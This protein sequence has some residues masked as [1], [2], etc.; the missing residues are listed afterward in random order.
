MC[1][2]WLSITNTLGAWHHVVDLKF[3]TEQGPEIAGSVIGR[4]ALSEG[5]LDAPMPDNAMIVI[6]RHGRPALDRHIWI[7]SEQ[8]VTWWAAYDAGGLATGQRVPNGLIEALRACKLIVASSLLRARETAEQAAP[9]R[10]VQIEERFVEA[11]LPPPHLPDFIKFR[12]RFWG[13]IARCTWYFGYNRDQETRQESEVRADAG[14]DWLIEQAR[15][16][17]S[18]GLLAHG[19]FNRMLRTCLELKGWTC[20]YDGRDS[21]WSHR[22]YRLK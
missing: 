13:V 20:V 6:A 16:H 18:V 19:W 8:Y 21:H 2:Q 5:V 4:T 1:G 3:E 10:D 22:I 12:P 14:A 7:N 9:D 17:G 11:P 15:V